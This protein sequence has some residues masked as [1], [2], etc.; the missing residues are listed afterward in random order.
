[1]LRHL[2]V[3]SY[4]CITS[5]E[6]PLLEDFSLCIIQKH[7][8]CAGATGKLEPCAGGSV[9]QVE[10]RSFV[11]EG[12]GCAGRAPGQMSGTANLL[13]AALHPADA[14]ACLAVCLAALD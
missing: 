2:Q 13:D 12:K 1:M 10:A 9:V 6:S 14:P 8:W 4:R 5:Y 11:M 7:N 3:C